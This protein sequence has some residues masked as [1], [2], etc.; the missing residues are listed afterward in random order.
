M[1]AD[2]VKKKTYNVTILKLFETILSLKEEQQDELLQLARKMAFGES[3]KAERK[4]CTVPV[5]YLVDNHLNTDMIKNTPEDNCRIIEEILLMY[6]NR[7]RD[8]VQVIK[9]HYFL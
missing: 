9:L 6:H 5:N 4:E 3:R 7:L 1:K 2:D 8:I